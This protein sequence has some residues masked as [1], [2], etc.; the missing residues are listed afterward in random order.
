MTVSLRHWTLPLILS[1]IALGITALGDTGREALQYIGNHSDR[2]DVSYRWVTGHFTHIGWRHTGLNLMGLFSIWVMYGTVLRSRIVIL[3]C[4][5]CAFGI[6]LG[7]HLLSPNTAYYVGLSGVLHGLLALV[8]VYSLFL[9][10]FGHSLALAPQVKW[11]EV[12]VIL[13]LWAKIAYE[14]FVGAVPMTAALAGDTVVIQAHLYGACIGTVF[15]ALLFMR[16]AL[17]SKA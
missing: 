17:R 12:I 8:A 1:L 10:Y 7:F 13:G 4:L 6:S 11:E 15:A 9:P 5:I 14:Q 16:S 3:F 2:L